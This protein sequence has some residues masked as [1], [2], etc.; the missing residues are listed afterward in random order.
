MFTPEII[1]RFRVPPDSKLRLKD[2]DPDWVQPKELKQLDKDALRQQALDVLKKDLEELTAAQELLWA[3]DTY[4]VLIVLQAMDAG[5]KDGLIKHVMSGLNPQGCR[6]HSFKKP[7]EE[8]LDHNFLWRCALR[9]PERGQIGIFNRSHYEEVIVV[10]VHPEFLERQKLPPGK[11][12]DGFWRKRYED[13]NAFEHH[14]D[15]NGTVILKFFLNISQEEQRKRLLSRLDDPEKQWKFQAQDVAEREHWDDY[16]AAYEQALA[17][18]ST[19]WAPWYV[20]PANHKWAARAAVAAILT[21]TINSLG[22]E[23]PKVGPEQREILAEARK[24]LASE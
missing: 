23:Y 24:K 3:G 13:I 12:G 9:L 8:E 7:S 5:G 16:M 18:T 22:L 19:K 4:S 20:I 21:R 17:A 11:R 10:K 1:D 14:L 6:V 15:R 2:C